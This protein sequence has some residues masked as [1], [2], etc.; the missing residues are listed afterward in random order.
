[1]VGAH[2]GYID[3]SVPWYQ[4]A[5]VHRA[6]SAEPKAEEPEPASDHSFPHRGLGKSSSSRAASAL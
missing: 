6:Q 4:E 2:T 5:T 3:F 1:M